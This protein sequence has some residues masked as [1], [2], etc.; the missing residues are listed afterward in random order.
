[1][2]S[3]DPED[4][5]D[6]GINDFPSGLFTHDQR[7]HGAIVLHF[8]CALYCFVLLAYVCNDYFLP[9]VECICV[10]L[11]LSQDVAGATFMAM[12]T[13]TPELFVNIIGTFITESDLG[14][15]AV[16]GSAV[17]NTFGVA[18]A[19]GLATI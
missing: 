16:V 3:E 12:A 13:S 8:L 17:F 6:R 14:V 9:S 10:D 18:A 1:G 15:G 5:I 11:N 2:G 19:S 4:C 7:L